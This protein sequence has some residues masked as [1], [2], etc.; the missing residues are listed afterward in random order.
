M[1]GGGNRGDR[2]NSDESA[3]GESTA[4]RRCRTRFGEDDI[5]VLPVVSTGIRTGVGRSTGAFTL[6]SPHAS[7]V[8]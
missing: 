3:A 5:V 4:L 7:P 8:W 1:M 2:G 6:P